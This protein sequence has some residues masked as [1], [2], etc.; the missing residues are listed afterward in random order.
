MRR[1]TIIAVI[2]VLGVVV[3]GAISAIGM[4]ENSKYSTHGGDEWRTDLSAALNTAESQQQ[5]VLLYFWMDNCASCEEFDKQMRDS[6]YATMDRFVL[7]AVR[8]DQRP[9]LSNRYNVTGTPTLVILDAEGN[10]VSKF[11][12][13]QTND[14]EGTLRDGYETWQNQTRSS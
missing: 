3:I 9:E 5:P 13:T 2:F 8:M 14:V 6:D 10:M 11:I 1:K 4:V 7:S 12:P